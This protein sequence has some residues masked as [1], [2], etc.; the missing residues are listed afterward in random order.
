MINVI[1]LKLLAMTLF[2]IT[3]LVPMLYLP[4]EIVVGFSTDSRSSTFDEASGTVTLN[5]CVL[6]GTIREENI[7]SVRAS[8]ADNSA[9]GIQAYQ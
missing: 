7:I 4:V 8:T 2:F 6:N 5:V 1:K 9:Q 3:M